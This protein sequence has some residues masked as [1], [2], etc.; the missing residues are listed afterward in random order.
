[1]VD[2]CER[3]KWTYDEFKE[4]PDR[5]IEA[6]EI[7]MSAQA[8]HQDEERDRWERQNSKRN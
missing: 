2:V 6:I 4:Q 3:F 5:F 1:M 7:K 8:R